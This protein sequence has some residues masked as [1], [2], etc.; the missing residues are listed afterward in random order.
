MDATEERVLD[1]T[2]DWFGVPHSERDAHTKVVVTDTFEYQRRLV[3]AR[4][5]EIIAACVAELNRVGYQ[6]VHW[7]RKQAA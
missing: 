2:L 1:E 5:G 7:L 4:F 3:R 6:I